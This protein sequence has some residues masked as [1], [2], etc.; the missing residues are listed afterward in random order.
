MPRLVHSPPKYRKHKASG[1]AVVTINGRDH[2]LGL[3]RSKASRREYDRLVGEWLARDRQPLV[4]DAD[5]LTVSELAARYWSY[6]TRKYV[7]YGQPTA[8]QHHLKTAAKH[9]LRLYENHF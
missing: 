9:L 3:Y 5:G 4:G 6:A 2:Y 7:R 1:Q 8:E